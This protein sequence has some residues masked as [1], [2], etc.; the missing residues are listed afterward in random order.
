M[1]AS[2]QSNDEQSQNNYNREPAIRAT[3]QEIN[4]AKDQFKTSEAERAPSYQLLPTGA[5]AN[6]VFTAGTLTN[7]EDV[8]NED[9]DGAYLKATI[10]A[11][12]GTVYAYAGRYS[13]EAQA[14]LREAEAPQFVAVCGKM[15]LYPE[16][17]PIEE[18]NVSLSPEWFQTIDADRRD[19][20]LLKNAMAT[21]ERA[22]GGGA[23]L[24]ALVERAEEQY[25]FDEDYTDTDFRAG[26][27]E[28]LE[29]LD[30]FHRDDEGATAGDSEEVP[31]AAA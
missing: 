29:S 24:D 9:S 19:E 18:R 1:S 27:V 28:V 26:A 3:V 13:E 30:E 20:I 5:G 6:R 7:V 2:Q 15:D 14:F 21:I 17:E 23:S 10:S 25:K 12:S 8:S 22:D 16:D 31:E 4:Q 11:E